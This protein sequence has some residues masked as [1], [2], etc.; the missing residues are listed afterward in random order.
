MPPP[1]A[2]FATIGKIIAAAATAVAGVLL[3]FNS[4]LKSLVPPIEGA[5][6]DLGLVSFGTTVILLALSLLIRRRIAVIRQAVLA[7]LSLTLVLSA[8]VTFFLYRD[9]VRTYVF[10]YPPFAE[11]GQSVR[12]IRGDL[13]AEGKIRTKDMTIPEAV[14][15]FGGPQIVV[16]REML[17]TDA[18][19]KEKEAGLELYYVLVATLLTV[20]IFVSAVTVARAL[21]THQHP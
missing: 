10:S 21:E 7:Y 15:Q 13:H 17:W 9:Y 12:M 4:F 2:P 1:P 11:T 3:L 20:A 8:F 18:S 19:M 5:D 6:L 14:R 16:S